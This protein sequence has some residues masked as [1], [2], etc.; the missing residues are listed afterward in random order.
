MTRA[1]PEQSRANVK[2]PKTQSRRAHTFHWKSEAQSQLDRWRAAE[3]VYSR[4]IIAKEY[5]SKPWILGFYRSLLSPHGRDRVR[6]I[7]DV[8]CGTGFFT[9]FAAN[10]VMVPLKSPATVIGVDLN[11]G[12]LEV[13][14][15]QSLG[16][17]VEFEYVQASAYSL[18]FRP[19]S[20]DL[21][22]CRTLLMHL[23]SPAGA[24]GEM[25]RAARSGGRV[26][27][28]EPDYGMV[29]FHDPREDPDFAEAIR[30][31][32]AAEVLGLWRT[33]GQDYEMG[34]RLPEL[35]HDAGLR[36]IML[37]GMFRS[38]IVPCD[39][40]IKVASLGDRYAAEL[41]YYSDEVN[42][43]EYRKTLRAGGLSTKEIDD[44][45]AVWRER[46][47]RRIK[48][49]Q[50]SSRA[51]E[52]DVGFLALPFFLVVGRKPLSK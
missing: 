10:Q 5:A 25:R 35:L 50:R 14:K 41:G 4:R 12:L 51:K 42:L 1:A 52:E 33:Y 13:A 31:V 16:G 17:E 21:V 11:R 8:G 45:L 9:R 44:Y 20:F 39:P 24:L 37:E 49:L 36:G 40:R 15:R 26:A 38:I 43:E 27:C 32:R 28:E 2:P 23:S 7:L 48:A 22:T 3:L 18:P 6:S 19:D 46:T 30:R 47:K 29:G 34:R